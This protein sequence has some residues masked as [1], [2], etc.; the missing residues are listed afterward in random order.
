MKFL[1]LILFLLFGSSAFAAVDQTMI[2]LTVTNIPVDGNTLMVADATRYWKNTV[3]TPSAQI[4]TNGTIGGATTNLWYHIVSYTFGTSI[5]YSWLATNQ[6]RFIGNPGYTFGASLT[7]T[8]GSLSTNFQQIE[9]TYPIIVPAAAAYPLNTD[10]TNKMSLLVADLNRY[11]SNYFNIS[12]DGLAFPRINHSAFTAGANVAANFGTAVYVKIDSG[13]SADFS[14]DGIVALGSKNGRYILVENATAFQCNIVNESA[15]ETTAA[16]RIVTGTSGTVSVSGVFGFVYDTEA[17]RWKLIAGGGGGTSTGPSGFPAVDTI[18]ALRARSVSLPENTVFVRGHSSF[19]DGGQGTFTYDS[20]SSATDDGGVVVAPNAGGGRWKRVLQGGD[21]QALWWGPTRTNATLQA[22]VNYV[23]GAGGGTVVA[24][25]GDWMLDSDDTSRFTMKSGV[26]LVTFGDSQLVVPPNPTNNWILVDFPI[27]SSNMTLGPAR[28]LGWNLL[29]PGGDTN[30]TGV[31]ISAQD[32]ENLTIGGVKGDNWYTHYADIGSGNVNLQM[33]DEN[34][35]PGVKAFG[36]KGYPVD[37]TKAIQDTVYYAERYSGVVDFPSSGT[38]RFLMTTVWITNNVPLLIRGNNTAIDVYYSQSGAVT[39]SQYSSAF[40][41]TSDNCIVEGLKLRTVSTTYNTLTEE[42]AITGYYVPIVVGLATNTIIRKNTFDVAT[43]RG[44][45]TEGSYTVIEQNT[46]LHGC[47]FSTGV[48]QRS[49]WLFR[50]SSTPLGAEGIYRSPIGVRVT[51]N[52]FT[53]SNAWKHIAFFSSADQFT[54]SRNKMIDIWSPVAA[55]IV[56]SGDTGVTDKN[57]TNIYGMS[58]TISENTITGTF[59]SEG[60]VQI[61]LNTPTNYVQTGFVVDSMYSGIVVDGNQI[62]GT[63]RGYNL[64]KAKGTKFRGGDCR[65]TLEHLYPLGDMSGWQVDGGYYETTGLSASKSGIYFGNAFL[66]PVNFKDVVFRN[67]TFKV[68]SPLDEYWF[69]NEDPLPVNGLKIE[70]CDITH[71]GAAGSGTAPAIFQFTQS[72][73]FIHLLGNRFYV[74]NNLNGRYLGYLEGTNCDFIVGPNQVTLLDPA[75]T[76]LGFSVTSQR[77][78]REPGFIQDGIL[79]VGATNFYGTHTVGLTLEDPDSASTEPVGNILWRSKDLASA[80]QTFAKVFATANDS[81]TTKRGKF[82]IQTSDAAGALQD[83]VS[84]DYQQ[85]VTVPQRIILATGAHFISGVGNPQGVVSAPV[86]SVF[87][88][89]DGSSGIYNKTNGTGNT[90]WLPLGGGGG[91]LGDVVGPASSADNRLV[92]FNSTS[93]KLLKQS[94]SFS[95]DG[96]GLYPIAGGKTI[97]RSTDPYSIGYFDSSIRI[98]GLG[99]LAK[100]TG[101]PQGA[102][103]ED[104]GSLV[105]RKDGAE[106]TT[107]YVK[108]TD[109]FPSSTNWYGVPTLVYIPIACSDETTAL[110]TGTAKRTFRMPGALTLLPGAQGVRASLVT[111]QSSGSVI[112]VDINEN[113]TTILSTKLTI[114]NTEKT[115]TT[116]VTPAVI[117]DLSLADDSEITVDIDTTGAGDATGLKIMLIGHK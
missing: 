93:G 99:I 61:R 67:A 2:T 83:A 6:I 74:T 113:G 63:G 55:L 18:A 85:Y 57:G 11:P 7:G 17:S 49:N 96:T 79:T 69:R 40:I 105:L 47:G 4:L 112:T 114:D 81:A 35:E 13:P 12:A 9:T 14:I 106:D 80:Y 110:T 87:T 38:N 50:A 98:G 28:L 109:D 23:S 41:F 95:D 78:V 59:G 44:I 39:N 70:N 62:S 72:T 104:T 117:S 36:A 65:V 88:R 75:A 107:L 24:G 30:K 26:T 60:A 92:L 8:W 52:S 91:G 94:T 3:V 100:L 64:I 51:D 43:G 10:R 21:Y 108:V 42:A 84:V 20:T 77:T 89:T 90:G 66:A 86:G 5:R 29:P 101:S 103:S 15:S 82:T 33:F 58:G 19:N 32:T 97:G 73:N 68:S 71:L 48:G 76:P 102:D 53:G 27:G 31:L 34:W 16:N 37:D 1:K 56:Y 22:A 25:G 116:A 46:F 45:L 111:A 115:S 54:F